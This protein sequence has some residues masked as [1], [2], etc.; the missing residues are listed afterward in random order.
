MGT[1]EYIDQFTVL[2][3]MCSEGHVF[4]CGIKQA[5]V[6]NPRSSDGH[7]CKE[8]WRLECLEH[9]QAYAIKKE[10]QCI[11]T[12]FVDRGKLLEWKCSEGHKFKLNYVKVTRDGSWCTTCRKKERRRRERAEMDKL[13]GAETHSGPLPWAKSASASFGSV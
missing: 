2:D 4:S 9:A 1:G 7:W 5:F 6:Y 3:W 8:C 11:S 10:G 13:D 12:R